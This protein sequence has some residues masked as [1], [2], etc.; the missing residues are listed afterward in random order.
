[1][2]VAEFEFRSPV[3]AAALRAAPDM[4]IEHEQFGALD[5]EGI[6]TFFWAS[7]GDFDRFE[8]GLSADSSVTETERLI[9][10][11]GRRLYR[12]T[13]AGEGLD[14]SIY[15]TLVDVDGI[16]RELTGSVDGWECT[17]MFPEHAAISEFQSALDERDLEFTLRTLYTQPE[18]LDGE[19]LSLTDH[20]HET[21]VKALENGYYDIP[22]GVQLN[23]L[24]EEL[25]IS[26]QA[27][28]ER[29]RRAHRTLAEGAV[30]DLN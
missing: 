9:E 11:D 16:V 15:P 27:C 25:G 3:I 5:G 8:E 23:A 6:R 29:L 4:V 22:R 28:S 2:I 30:D 12:T 1:M 21:V 18:S 14:A 19:A 24:S 26:H 13:L 17:A 20:Q 7:G 10:L